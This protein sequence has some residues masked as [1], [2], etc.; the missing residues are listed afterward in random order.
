MPEIVGPEFAGRGR[1][2]GMTAQQHGRHRKPSR[3]RKIA[4]RGVSAGAVVGV[5]TVG[6]VVP[7]SAAPISTWDSVAQCESS[8]NWHINTGNGYY[9]GLQFKQSTWEAFGG[10]AYAPRADLATK[11]QQIAVAERTLA[12]Q[13]WGAWTCAAMVGASGSP[14]DRDVPAEQPSATASTAGESAPEPAPQSSTE[15]SA[16]S[17]TES[18]T[19][20][21][22]D[23]RSAPV[24]SQRSSSPSGE[25]YRVVAGDTLS[26]IAARLGVAGGWPALF[27]LNADIISDPNLIYPGQVLSLG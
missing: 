10:L 6:A 17:S 8:G 7:A 9:G 3:A 11:E 5:L 22:A 26:E 2:I 19:A 21:S 4:M 13:G 25:T 23:T 15:S 18:S 1:E 27:H 14:Q 24:T 20:A 16:A 12:V